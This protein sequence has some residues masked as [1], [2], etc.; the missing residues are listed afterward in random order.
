MAGHTAGTEGS[1][2]TKEE[3]WFK[4]EV[5]PKYVRAETFGQRNEDASKELWRAISDALVESGLKKVLVTSFR[6]G[7]L[8]LDSYLSLAKRYQDLVSS[9]YKFALAIAG[10]DFKEETM[11]EFV[12]QSHGI[13]IR[14]FA[15]T[16]D[17]LVW[18]LADD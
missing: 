5:T 8:T 3:S 2:I 14:T 15:N 13:N 4:I 10:S 17:A 6:D 18:L 9:E 12:G 11:D 1:Q 7:A 16:N